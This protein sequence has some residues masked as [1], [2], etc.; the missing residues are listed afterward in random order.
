[1]MKR[2]WIYGVKWGES[3]RAGGLIREKVSV[4]VI[5]NMGYVI[6]K[7]RMLLSPF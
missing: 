4:V 6:A 7:M 5:T 1:M 2:R 3:E